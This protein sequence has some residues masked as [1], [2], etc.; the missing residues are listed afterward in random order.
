LGTLENLTVT[1]IQLG[2]KRIVIADN[3]EDTFTI[4]TGTD[5]ATTMVTHDG[6]GI[7]GHFEIDAD[8]DIILD[9]NRQ[10]KLEP[11]AGANIL[12]DG[13]LSV[14]AG[15]VIP[16]ATAHNAAGTAVSIGAGATTAGTTNNIAGGNLTI[17]G[18]QGKGSGAGG[19][20]IFQTAN[21]SGSGSSL[22]SLATAL[23]IS[24]DLSAT[25]A[26]AVSITGALTMP[27]DTVTFAKASGVTPNVYDSKIKLIPSDFAANDDGGNT[28][29]GVGF[30]EDASGGTPDTAYGMRAS[31]SS[32]ELFA[33]V[34]IPQG[35]KATH[36]M[37]YAKGNYDVEVF[38]GNIE[39]TA[40][41]SRSSGGAANTEVDMDD[42]NATAINFLAISVNTTATTHKVYGGYVTIAAI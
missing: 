4:T 21:A 18:G 5:G 14:D 2:E 17:H 39:G 23:T 27:D 38:E 24:D 34:S 22:N 26:G 35:M 13:V 1:D 41:T 28:K 8:G 42:V 36:V 12:L 15:V 16:V 10:I 40:F 32:V 11:A 3:E 7:G 29:F 25:F 6:D 30:V 33:F 19:D 20:I 9:S 37:I 31:N